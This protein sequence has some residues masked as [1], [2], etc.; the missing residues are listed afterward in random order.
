MN[1]KIFKILAL[2][3][4]LVSNINLSAKDKNKKRTDSK[5][6]ILSEEQ[7]LNFDFS[8]AE[9]NK[10]MMIGDYEAAI[11]HFAV[12][13]KIDQ[14]SSVVR[15]Q[16]ANLYISQ[17][18]LDNALKLARE[19]VEYNPQNTWY[20]LQL[21][22]IYKEKAMI[23]QACSVYED[24][25][26]L[27]PSKINYYYI[28]ANL[29]S[30]VEKFEQAVEELN[31][32]E[33]KFGIS[34]VVSIEKQRLYLNLKK[35]K[36]AYGEIEKLIKKYP[37]RADFYGLL[38]EMYL[39]DKEEGKALKIYNKILEIEPDNGIVHYYLS[40][41][42]FKNKKF[43]EGKKS[44]T[45]MFKSSKLN[46]EQKVQYL[47]SILLNQ[48]Q[49]E[50]SD[51]ELETY[52]EILEKSHPDNKR[53]LALYADYFKKKNDF[54][55]SRKYLNRIIKID[56]SSFMVWQELLFANNQLEDY[57]QMEKTGTE[58][59]KYFPNQPFFYVLKGIAE[60]QLNK[61]QI[62][63]KTFE[64][65]LLYSGTN[66]EMNIQLYSYLGDAY[67]QLERNDKAYEFYDKVL[68]LDPENVFVLNNYSYFLSVDMKDLDKAEKM[69]EICVKKE[70]NNHTYLDTY[71]WTLYK[72]SKFEKAKEMIERSIAN[73][74]GKSA[75]IVEHYGDILY[76]LGDKEAA[77][78]QWK[79]A[80]SIGE[81][82]KNLKEKIKTG[83]LV[84]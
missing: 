73:G 18:D 16:L 80:D 8:F 79:K 39:E 76:K 67:H 60:L 26:K 64:K 61:T 43:S 84:E 75:V 22:G 34:D 15:Y 45:K 35:R 69:A 29:Y 3:L 50:I 6:V 54:R 59:I 47:I 9:A 2:I 83:N 28:K 10:A 72:N 1:I 52:L 23:E 77:K 37:H 78:E 32:V 19:A 56:K 66:K 11:S 40:D 53:V 74:G 68:A 21:A 57:E 30:S 13:L 46:S 82:S 49:Y 70:P 81:G 20:Q 24:L 14:S 58:A 62:A 33:K 63:V 5:E 25:I 17:K 38:A 31:R 51:D 41:H 36:Q 42:Y 27:D 71:A 12:C 7:K 55:G 65:G 44:L 4:L 48:K